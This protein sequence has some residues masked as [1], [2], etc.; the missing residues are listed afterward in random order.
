MQDKD[1]KLKLLRKV[2]WKKADTCY[3]LSHINPPEMCA[4]LPLEAENLCVRSKFSDQIKRG[5]LID[6]VSFAYVLPESLFSE[7][8][9]TSPQSLPLEK[10]SFN[11]VRMASGQRV[12]INKQAKISF[13][14]GPH[15]FQDSLLILPTMNSVILGNSFFLKT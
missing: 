14:I 10:P 15:Y 11:S 9:L 8:N 3:E 2:Q 4:L 13:R 12:P 1:Q 7:L 5:A 6:A